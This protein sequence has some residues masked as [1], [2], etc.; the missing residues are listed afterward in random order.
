MRI[1]EEEKGVAECA[2]RTFRTHAILLKKVP[3][4]AAVVSHCV[5]GD[6]ERVTVIV[7]VT[8]IMME[9]GTELL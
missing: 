2:E 7:T 4:D 8:V 5:G 6:A 9:T 1:S 3:R